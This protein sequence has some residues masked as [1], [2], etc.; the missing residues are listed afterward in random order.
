MKKRQNALTAMVGGITTAN[1]GPE[2]AF[3]VKMKMIVSG[4]MGMVSYISRMKTTISGMNTITRK[5][6]RLM[7]ESK[8]RLL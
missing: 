1:A 5:Q 8:E 7:S 4:A 3:A 2:T 6:A